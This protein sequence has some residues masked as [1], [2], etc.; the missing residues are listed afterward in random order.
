MQLM[1]VAGGRG[2]T[3]WPALGA[4]LVVGLA[5]LGTA[6]QPPTSYVA[7]GDSY[8]AGPVIPVQRTDYPGCLRSDHNYP[9][10]IKSS[11]GQPVF[12]DASCSGAQTNDMTQ[13]Q[14]VSPSPDNPP[15]FDRLDATT[16]V[17]T[18]GIGGNDIGFTEIAKS[19]SSPTPTGTPCQDQWVKGG[20]DLITDRINATAPKVAAVLQGIHARSPQAR[21]YVVGYPAILPESGP[22]CWPT[23]PITPGDV[24]YLRAKEKE[25]NAM[26]SAQA[27][28]NGAVFVD[29]YTPSIGHD[30]CQLPTV[31]WVEPVVPVNP[32]APIHPNAAGMQGMAQAVL[33][34]VQAPTGARVA[35]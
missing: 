9:A 26:L 8:T 27:A 33:A 7:L 14:H 25:L 11:V 35:G 2:R 22:G 30:A 15:Q 1:H 19:C 3:R 20:D 31:R 12:R 6:C 13:T 18:I 10:L 29:T 28:V 24:P 5:L 4:L 21:V 16:R 32:A 17:V 34:A 23:M